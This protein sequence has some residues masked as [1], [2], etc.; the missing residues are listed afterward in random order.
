VKSILT[1]TKG[2]QNVSEKFF[3]KLSGY[4]LNSIV[5]R[6]NPVY[7]SGEGVILLGKYVCFVGNK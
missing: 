6:E 5:L 1:I 7:V 2:F 4:F 3:E